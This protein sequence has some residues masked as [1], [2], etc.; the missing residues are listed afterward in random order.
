MKP[1]F[2]KP[3]VRM[4]ARRGAMRQHRTIRQ[5]A[6][7]RQR[8]VILVSALVIT[9]MAAVVAAALFFD[10]GLMARRA[11]A[12]FSLEQALQ[13]GQGAEV[14]AAQVLREDSGQTDTPQENWAQPVEPVEVQ[15]GV[16]LEARLT[17][18]T[19]RFNLNSL[20]TAEGERD[21]NAMRMFARLLELAELEPRWAD[22]VSDWIDPDT[23]PAPDGGEDGLYLAQTPPHRAANL[24]ITSVSELLQMPGFTP[25]MYARLAPHVTALPASART[26]NVCTAGGVVLDALFALHETDQ[27]H[28]EYSTL[29]DEEMAERREGECYPRRAA[30][31]SGQQAMAQLAAERSNWFRLETWV[32][33]GSAQF[34]LYSLVQRDGS[35]RVQAVARSMGSE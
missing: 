6:T 8:G 27:K 15:E 33:I 34:A 2:I 28:V 1:G 31:T 14:L 13:I 32:N 30:I 20:I 16:V 9:A 22:M 12:N 23:L 25:E 26:I 35:G 11:L 18:A 21:E 7:L 5:R 17:D 29:T 4:A 3:S 24:A 10:T 19:A